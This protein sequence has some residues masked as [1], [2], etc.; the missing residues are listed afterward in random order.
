MTTLK[1]DGI[2]KSIPRSGGW[3]ARGVVIAEQH[4]QLFDTMIG[5]REFDNPGDAA[6]WLRTAAAERNIDAVRIEVQPVL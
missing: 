3:S 4:A 1:F 6:A 5:P 2:V